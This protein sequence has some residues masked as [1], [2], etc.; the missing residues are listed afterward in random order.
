MNLASPTVVPTQTTVP[1]EFNVPDSLSELDQWLLWRFEAETKVPYTLKG[2]KASSTDARS[3][4]PF[5]DVVTAWRSRRGFYDGVGFVFTRDDPFTGID[6]DDCIDQGHLKQE[7][8]G[9][10]ECFADSYSEVSPSGRGIKIWV[11]GSIPA[12]VPKVRFKNGGGI[13]I[14]DCK[15]YFTV[16]GNGWR[17]APL[18]VEDH[19]QDLQELYRLVTQHRAGRWPLQ[20]LLQGLIPYGQQHDTL[21]SIMGTLRNRRVCEEAILACLLIV[22]EKQCEKPGTSKHIEQMVRSSRNWYKKTG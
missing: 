3:W 16:T 12:N 7:F 4:A 11:R 1:T 10:V 22:N 15:R 19:T 2:T 18:E 5:D 20:P 17:G 9:I 8:S 13:E 21:I 6:L 14:Y